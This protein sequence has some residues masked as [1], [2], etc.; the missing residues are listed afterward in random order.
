MKVLFLDIDGVLNPEYGLKKLSNNW[1]DMSVFNGK[2]PG[3]TFCPE[4]IEALR[5]IIEATGAKI[6]ISSSWRADGIEA[7]KKLWKVKE[8]PGEII[9]ITP[10]SDDRVRGHEIDNWLHSKGCFYPKSFWDAP[11]WEE[12]RE[13][14]EIEGFCI[15]DDDWDI[16]IL[17][18]PHY[19]N[20]DKY[21]GLAQEGKC[22]EVI[23]KLNG[24]I[25]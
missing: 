16:F 1:T 8:L 6:V 13:E 7:M 17:Q 18:Q 23:E 20:V 2:D 10:L 21:Y 14:C 9:D 15:V 5:K 25:A 3:K 4:S 22:E 12:S 24:E 11:A 19:V